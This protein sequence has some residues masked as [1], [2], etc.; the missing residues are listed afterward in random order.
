MPPQIIFI[1]FS[2]IVMF[3]FINKRKV[4]NTIGGIIM[5]LLAPVLAIPL[6][7]VILMFNLDTILNYKLWGK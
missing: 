4:Q 2:Y 7:F 5:F 3:I 1:V 6:L